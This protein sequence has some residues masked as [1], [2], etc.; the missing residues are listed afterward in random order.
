MLARAPEPVAGGAETGHIAVLY[1]FSHDF[2]ERPD[3]AKLELFPVGKLR[4]FLFR[5]SADFDPA[6][7]ID[8]RD[9]VLH[10]FPAQRRIFAGG[11]DQSRVGNSQAQRCDHAFEIAVAGQIPVRGN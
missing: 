10:Q 3:I 2:V 8:L 11:K 7:R 1:Q 9:A 6:A 4:V 5:V